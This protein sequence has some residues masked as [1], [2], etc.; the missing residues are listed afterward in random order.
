MVPDPGTCRTDSVDDPSRGLRAAWDS[1]TTVAYDG[2]TKQLGALRERFPNLFRTPFIRRG[3]D[4]L[5]LTV[6][7]RDRV[8]FPSADVALV[9]G[10]NGTVEAR[11]PTAL[12]RALADAPPP[13]ETPGIAGA[14]GAR[15]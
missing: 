9:R 5:G 12:W 15:R 11:D 6:A 4:E 7:V 10:R 13:A 14:L 8:T 1:A 2:T 3:L